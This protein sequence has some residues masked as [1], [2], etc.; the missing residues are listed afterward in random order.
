M[1]EP[2]R[3]LGIQILKIFNKALLAK[4][5]WRLLRNPS[6]IWSLVLQAKY[7]LNSNLMNKFIMGKRTAYAI[8]ISIIFWE[9]SL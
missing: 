2:L 8:L 1:P 7:F 5:G 9:F 4:N 3:G 6:S